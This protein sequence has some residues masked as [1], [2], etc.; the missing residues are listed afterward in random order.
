MTGPNPFDANTALLIIDM[1]QAIDSPVWSGKNNPA[2]L[3]NLI[4]VLERWRTLGWPVYHIVHDSPYP[5]SPYRPG[6]PGNKI[7]TELKPV[8]GEQVVRKRTNSAF[9]STSLEAQLRAA[10]HQTLVVGGVV[11]NNSVEA[12]ARTAGDLGFSVYVLADGTA[13]VGKTDRR[14]R[15]WDAEDVHQLALANLEGEYAKVVSVQELLAKLPAS[16]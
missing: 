10:G 15:R 11:T 3:P 12:T 14:G 2:L 13:T 16:A 9:L 8:E 4:K 1:Q 5:D 7:K 6:Q